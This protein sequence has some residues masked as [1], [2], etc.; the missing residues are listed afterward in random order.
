MNLK[1]ESRMGVSIRMHPFEL[2]STERI[3][4]KLPAIGVDDEEFRVCYI[5]FNELIDVQLEAEREGW[6]AR[7]SS[8]EALRSQVKEAPVLLRPLMREER[9]GVLRCY[10]CLLIF[11]T[12]EGGSSGGVATMDI[13]R[14]RI[15]SFERVDGN[16][17][18][19]EAFSRIFSL[20]VGG[21]SMVSKI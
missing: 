9:H 14:T 5:D 2:M 3:D 12:L 1:Q 19:R 16:I 17:N 15:E 20:A 11:S 8:V 7:W 21:V 6:S 10:R 13:S 4:V 18:T